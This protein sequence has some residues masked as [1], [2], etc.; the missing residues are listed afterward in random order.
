MKIS[1][2][3]LRL[4]PVTLAALLF[5]N[6]RIN[7]KKTETEN[8][9][10]VSALNLIP[11]IKA[12]LDFIPAAEPPEAEAENKA[13]ETAPVSEASADKID[14]WNGKE[15]VSMELEDYIV[16]VVAGE[17]P[18]SY[19]PEALKA[20]AAAARTFT[21]KHILGEAHCK[22]GHTVCTDSACCQAF[23]STEELK[24][25]WGDSFEEYYGKIK[26]AVEDTKG[27]VITCGGEII[28]AFYHSSSA[29]KTEDSEAVFAASFPY[30]VPVESSG[31]ENYAGFASVRKFTFPE[32]IKKVN[33][34]FP[35]AQ[36][37]DV[38][39]E[40]A[41][42]GRTDSGRVQLVR[43]GKTV[44]NGQQMRKLFDLHSTD[45]SIEINN[46]RITISC[47]G[48]GHGVGMSQC[49]ANEMAKNGASFEEILKHY[50]TGVKIE[51]LSQYVHPAGNSE[52]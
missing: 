42:W 34:A 9:R 20:Q 50:Y 4:L 17:M 3:F 35:E 33:K 43:L 11:D 44:I 25:L 31:E 39:N 41:I 51:P 38:R 40:V 36:L 19:E 45:F 12:G 15:A 6:G 24:R 21:A 49:G 32:F 2:I 1:K 26:K 16:H 23:K 47:R 29:G 28:N 10:S 52:N 22:S 8:Y 5:L 30:L 48:F 13:A 18:A 7:K 46:N 27:L 14:V 37:K